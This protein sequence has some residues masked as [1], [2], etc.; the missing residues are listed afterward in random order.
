MPALS[1]NTLTRQV[2]MPVW[3]WTRFAP[4]VSAAVSSTCSAD[5]GDFL[6]TEHGRYLY[7][8]ISATGFWRYDT[9]TDMFQQLSS[10]PVSPFNVS[11][12]KLAG[13]YGPEGK[14]LAATSSTLTMPS[15]TSMEAALDYDIVIV[16]GTGAG[17][18]RK[19]I[20]IA[21]PVVHDSGIVTAA[22]NALGGITMTDTL[23]AWAGNQYAGY[24]VRVTGNAGVSQYRRILSNAAT[25]LTIGDSTQMNMRLNNPAIFAPAI[26]ATAGS[27]TAY[28][29]ESQMVTVNS[30]WTVT[31]DTTSVFRIQSGM[32]MLVSPNAATATAPFYTTQLYDILTDTWYVLP[33]MTNVLAAAVSDISLERMS[34]NASIWAKGNAT[35]GTTTSLVDASMGVNRAA[36]TTDEWAGYWL[37]ISSGTGEGQL[38]QVTSNTGTTL[39]WTSAG[40]APD[41]TSEY[42]IVGFDAGTATSG[43]ASTLTD[44]T[45]S[46]STNRWANYAVRIM[47]GTG[48][49]QVLPIVSNTATAL[50]IV[51]AWETAPDNTSVYTIQGDPDKAFVFAGGIA[52]MPII[53]FSSST[54]S[55]GRQQDWGIA[56]NASATVAGY[57][58][59]AIASLANATTTATVTTAHPHQFR[60]GELVTVRGATDANFN[61]TNVAIVAVPT[62]TT[63]TYTMAGTPTATTLAGAQSTTTLR[64]ASKNWTVNEHAGRIVYMYAATPTAASGATTGQ[65]VRIASNTADTLTLAA[66][67]TAPTNGVS[68]YSICT[69]SALGAIDSGV[70]TGTHSTTTLQDT[71]KTWAVNI[72]AGKRCRIICGPGSPAEAIISSN[73]ANTLTFSAALGAAP[74]T[75][76]TGYAIL[77]GV[78][79]GT[80]ANAN[81]AF[82]TSDE[83]I[84]GKYMYCTR[85][86]AVAGFD[87]LDVTTDLV[88]SIPTSPATE[89][90]TTGTMTAYDGRD[91]IYFHKDATQR[92][93]SL[94]VVTSNV[95]GASMYPYAAPTAIL[96][97]RMEIFETK[98]RLKYLWL[99]R[100]SFAECFR[101]LL[102]W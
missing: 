30:P 52:A 79:K 32:I 90:L 34:E 73:T 69:S 65:I 64:D 7:Y 96:G 17:Q 9:W 2:D 26:G 13:A 74:V 27:Q 89:T 35:G 83:T 6:E 53:N 10:P 70:A 42:M 16:S 48:A 28:S 56:R 102:F 68:R 59:V 97:N 29:I 86:G 39:N 62:A 57:Q 94:N 33:T 92:I 11:A 87:R 60:A 98:D 99:N 77:G 40:T 71:S 95:N 101:C 8:L 67:V 66:T 55:Y 23:K 3:E 37:Y 20:N 84:R 78:V 72:H 43:A 19:I 93:Y 1:K 44:S 63:F 54:Q 46:W 76:Q 5:N 51:G 41:A 80:G 31:P 75:A 49:G 82:G 85:G 4:A 47:S 50:T 12:M 100:A 61:V 38:R 45:K 18:R 22:A 21:D 88:T 91:R 15:I 14:V 81:W 58:P 24:T 25:V 36:W